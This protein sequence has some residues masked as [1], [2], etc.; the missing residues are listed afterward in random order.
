MVHGTIRISYILLLRSAP[1]R[2]SSGHVFTFP[3]RIALFIVAWRSYPGEGPP[4][5]PSRCYPPPA[6]VPHKALNR[7]HA[8]VFLAA[9][10]C[11]VNLKFI[12]MNVTSRTRTTI[13]SGEELLSTKSIHHYIG[14]FAQCYCPLLPRAL[15]LY[16]RAYFR[17]V[18]WVQCKRLGLCSNRQDLSADGSSLQASGR[19]FKRQYVIMTA[20]RRLCKRDGE[21]MVNVSHEAIA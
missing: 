6:K 8:V 18:D 4:Q 20:I 1:K 7:W 17:S 10:E 11:F 5:I 19:R 12:S 15:S 21:P 2:E 16:P 13:Y 14:M 9:Y 3:S